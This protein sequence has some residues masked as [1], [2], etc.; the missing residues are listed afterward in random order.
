M[1]DIYEKNDDWIRNI[2]KGLIDVDERMKRSLAE[3]AANISKNGTMQKTTLPEIK[4]LELLMEGIYTVDVERTISDMTEIIKNTESQLDKV[5]TINSHL[6]KDLKVSKEMIAYLKGENKRLADKIEQ[7]EDDI[8]HKRELQA[9]I[10]Q[11]VDERN[12]SHN[13]IN[14][15]RHKAELAQVREGEGQKR[16]YDLIE[17]T[18]DNK[19]EIGYLENKLNGT[20]EQ[21]GSVKKKASIL[22]SENIA[23]KDKINRLEAQLKESLDERYKLLRELKDSKATIGEIRSSLTAAKLQSKRYFYEA[24]DE[25][26]AEAISSGS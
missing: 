4:G 17:E 15:F 21:L 7:M 23:Y 26:K 14:D 5:L 11:L 3:D 13:I 2:H 25:K 22:Y 1:S 16:I 6:G 12:K 20:I 24:S 18:K 10:D 8:P 9:V 19:A